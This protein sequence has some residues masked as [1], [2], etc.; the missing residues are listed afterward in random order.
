ME[1]RRTIRPW[2]LAYTC[3]LILLVVLTGIYGP[4]KHHHSLAYNA[5]TNGYTIVLLVG[6]LLYSFSCFTALVRKIWKFAFVFGI[7]GFVTDGFVS[8]FIDRKPDGPIEPWVIIVLMT[9][10][11]FPSF[12]ANFLLGYG[13]PDHLSRTDSEPRTEDPMHDLVYEVRKLH[14]T[15]RISWIVATTILVALLLNSY[16]GFRL[17]RNPDSWVTV[18]RLAAAARYEEALKIAQR[19]AEKEPENP[20]THIVLGNL[21]LA[22]GQIHQA[23]SSYARAYEL[24]PNDYNSN[25]LNAVRQRIDDTEPSPSPTP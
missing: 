13:D 6:N 1:I 4:H 14:R 25:L 10:F 15:T 17:E 22:L 24:F 9:A 11:L 23:E 19:L 2:M 5:L 7:I 16:L 12:R 3:A 20:G 18:N 21:H 8:T